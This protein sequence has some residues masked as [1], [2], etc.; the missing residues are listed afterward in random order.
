M[1]RRSVRMA[2]APLPSGDP[3]PQAPRRSAHRRAARIGGLAA[4]T[5]AALSGVI[6]LGGLPMPRLA[7]LADLLG[8]EPGPAPGAAPA[9]AS[10]SAPAQSAAAVPDTDPSASVPG[11]SAEREA[12]PPEQDGQAPQAVVS[13]EPAP[14]PSTPFAGG[15]T[16]RPVDPPPVSEAPR[17]AQTVP[18]PVA[19]PPEFRRPGSADPSRRVDRPSRRIRATAVAPAAEDD[20]SFFEKLFGIE[21]TAAP[22]LAYTA[23]ET[24]PVAV[25]PPRRLVPT[26]IPAPAPVPS[27]GG[28]IAVYDIS[29]RIVTLPNGERL[30]AHSGLGEGLDDARYVDLRMRGPTPPGTYDLTEREQPFH[31]VRAL[32]LNPVGGSAAVYGRAGLLAHT[33]MLGASGASNGCVSFKDY[34]RFLQ[35]YLRGEVQRLVVVTGR[36]QD[37]PPALA[38]RSPSAPAS[39]PGALGGVRVASLP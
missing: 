2:Q 16:A 13:V 25:A 8:R 36:G 19:R 32:R 26:P 37:A 14:E 27:A 35:A 33:Y 18:L 22:A 12:P 39:S 6:A 17:L 20:R 38:S 30:E 34:E 11:A 1:E 23:L 24:N 4:L 28:G 31:G 15:E 29:A 7:P 9:D 10:P 3:A 21:R 5:L